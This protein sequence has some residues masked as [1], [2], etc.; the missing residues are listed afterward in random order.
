MSSGIQVYTLT[1]NIYSRIENINAKWRRCISKTAGLT[2]Y[3]FSQPSDI[4][5]ML[6]IKVL[7]EPAPIQVVCF[8]EADMEIVPLSIIKVF[9]ANVQKDLLT[10]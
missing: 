4:S 10:F 6:I 5:T 8:I 1:L 3:T 9:T 2:L 7:T